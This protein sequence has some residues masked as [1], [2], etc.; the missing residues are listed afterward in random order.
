MNDRKEF[1][2]FNR[3]MLLQ[4]VLLY[5]GI[6]GGLLVS[7][8]FFLLVVGYTILI[9]VFAKTE[10][11]F[12]HLLFLLPYSA[13][14][15]LSPTST[16]LFTY[17]MIGTGVILLFRKKHVKPIPIITIMIFVVYA[18][19]GMGNSYTTVLKMIA[20]LLLLYIFVNTVE[21]D[22]FKNQIMAYGL[23]MLGS[24]IIGTMKDTWV[25][26]TVY[27]NDI[28]FVYV[29]GVR[30]LR[31]SGLNYDPNYYAIGV[32][33]VIFLIARLLFHKEGNRLFAGGIMIALAVFGFLSY[34]KMFLLSSAILLAIFVFYRMK[35]PKKIL[36]TLICTALILLLFYRLADNSGYLDTI[37]ERL[38]GGDISTGRFDMWGGYLEYILNSTKTLLLG[39]GLGSPYYLSHGPHNAYIEVVFFLGLLGGCLFIFTIVCIIN[40]VRYVNKRIFIHRAL[41]FM[42][43]VMIAT[44]GIVTVNDLM[45]YCMLIWISMNME[46]KE[47]N[48]DKR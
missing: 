8:Y 16:S 12:Y 21:K 6:W 7:N 11:T 23:G 41:I 31:F 42:F 13:I 3:N 36:T 9:S 44:L 29:D 43:L 28:D 18:I 10:N 33:I 24:S 4:C 15:K 35:S 38:S 26:L 27:F 39:D 22:D 25:R 45:F 19:L 20:G 5:A 37:M 40:S 47:L 2:G 48:Y 14:F 17:L 34:S 46:G 32:V 30:S 1:L